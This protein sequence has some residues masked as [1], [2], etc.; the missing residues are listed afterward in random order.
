MGWTLYEMRV[1]ARLS[2]H[3][4]PQDGMDES[5]WQEF[6]DRVEAI[7]R[8]HRYADISLDVIRSDP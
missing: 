5:A 4:S 2:S 3:N 8:E 6:Q 7:A 1:S